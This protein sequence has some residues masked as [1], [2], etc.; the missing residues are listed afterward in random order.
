[1]HQDVLATFDLSGR[2]AI[3]TG[4]SR[5]IGRAIAIGF[6]SLGAQ[7]VVASRNAD[8]CA[9]V[10]ADIS[11]DGGSA[12]AVPTHVGDP[13]QLD[14]LVARTVSAFRGIDI[15]VN[16]AATPLAQPIGQITPEAFSKSH[17]VNL[18]GPVFLVQAALPHLRTSDHA[19]VINVLTAGVFTRGGFVSLYVSAKAALKSFT[20]SMAAELAGEGIRV[21]GLAP[22]TVRTDMVLNTP[23]EFQAAAVDAQSIKRMAE[24]EE[25]VPAA[26]FLASDASGFMTGQTLV[27]DGGMTVH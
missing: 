17:E 2:T 20:Q 7:V 10:A 12:L 26:L 23:P 16:N 1:M 11:A 14:Q 5:G 13:A 9:A 24:P 6:A 21:N 4:G 15:V 3:I 19:S 27:I 22:G 8:A 18:R 25:M